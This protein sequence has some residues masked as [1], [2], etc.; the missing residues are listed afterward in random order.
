MNT[1][2]SEI[3]DEAILRELES[4]KQSPSHDRWHTDR[5]LSF[6]KQLHKL[7]DG[8]LEVIVAA[9][10]LHDLGRHD[11][12]KHG[13][14]SADE[15]V[16][17]SQQILESVVDDEKKMKLILEA[18]ADHAKPGVT[19]RSLE[20]RILK[21]ADFLAGF[22]AWGILRTCLWTGESGETVDMVLD[23]L[24]RRMPERLAGLEFLESRRLA[25]K[26]MLF[27]KLFLASLKTDPVLEE[28][29]HKGLYIGFDGISGSGKGAQIALLKT[30]LEK[31]G[32]D[33]VTVSEPPEPYRAIRRSWE[34]LCKEKKSTPDEQMFLL[35]A[36]RARLSREHLWPALKSGSIILSDRTFMSTLVYQKNVLYRSTMLAFSHSFI[37]QFDLFFLLDLPVE[38]AYQR[39]LTRAGG[40]EK[41]LSE[42]ERPESLEKH[43]E[44]FLRSTEAALSP[45]VRRVLLALEVD[46]TAARIWAEVEALLRILK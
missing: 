4:L 11:S 16:A 32:Q 2:R 28:R 35:L 27:V 9:A 10:R 37:P 43:R 36:S 21:D 45:Q 22:G 15:S 42:H 34:N 13:Q 20:G 5:V 30:R 31:V 26:E 25:S 39:I 6:A 3:L 44:Q 17:F 23:R 41:K 7:Y 18:I 12:S 14:D 38:I 8:D 33:V 40:D 29:P 24:E 19:P 46:E 1:R